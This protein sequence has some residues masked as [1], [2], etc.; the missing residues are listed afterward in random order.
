MYKEM[1]EVKE[2]YKNR[3]K[4]TED[5]LTRQKEK[6]FLGK[7]IYSWECEDI[8]KLEA[9]RMAALEDKKLAFSLMKT[10]ETEA[11]QKMKEEL[12]FI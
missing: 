7:D 5:E 4:K 10:K 8:I 2:E 1:N 9:N 3:V 6:L 11:L 12:N